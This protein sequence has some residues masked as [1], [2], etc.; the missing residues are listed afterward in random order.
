[1][2]ERDGGGDG[3]GGIWRHVCYAGLEMETGWGVGGL[4]D[5]RE[6]MVIS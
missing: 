3:G 6:R 5:E 1:M 4:V 2:M